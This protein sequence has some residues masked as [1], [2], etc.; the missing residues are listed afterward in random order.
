MF[1]WSLARQDLPLILLV[2]ALGCMFDHQ[3]DLK[4]ALPGSY[5]TTQPGSFALDMGQRGSE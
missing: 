5:D 3:G 1:D 4:K 2:A